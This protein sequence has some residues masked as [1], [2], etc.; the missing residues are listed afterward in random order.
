VRGYFNRQ[1]PTRNDA[2]DLIM[3]RTGP[4]SMTQSPE[5]IGESDT[6]IAAAR[7][8]P[9]LASLPI[10]G[11][12]DRLKGMLTDRDIGIRGLADDRSKR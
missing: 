5:C 4:G 3:T 8:I 7:K 12:D 10:C 11:P 1:T 2:K 9:D 6:L